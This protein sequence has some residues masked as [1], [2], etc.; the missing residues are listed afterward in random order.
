MIPTC[1][2]RQ[3]P[4]CGR[5]A[6]G[7]CVQ[8]AQSA[9]TSS[10]RAA[11]PLSSRAKAELIAVEGELDERAHTLPV[12]T[13][14]PMRA[15]VTAFHVLIAGQLNSD[16]DD[17]A[18]ELR[19]VAAASRLSYLV[20]D[21]L[22]GMETTPFGAGAAD[23]LGAYVDVDPDGSQLAFLLTYGHFCE[24]MPEVHRDYYDVGGNRESGFTLSHV[25]ADFAAFEMRDIILTE[26]G[27]PF[28]VAFP[29]TSLITDFDRLAETAPI[30]PLEIAGPVYQQLYRFYLRV[31]VEPALVT[32]AG[33]V[34]AAGVDNA[35]FVRFRAAVYAI[36]DVCRGLS[37]AIKRRIDKEAQ[38]DALEVEFM[39]WVAVNWSREFVVAL[40]T[41]LSGLT[42]V[43]VDR[44]L[45][46]FTLGLRPDARRVDHAGDGYL[47][48]FTHL[49]DSLLFSGDLIRLFL[50]ARNVLFVVNRLDKRRFDDLVSQAMEPQLIEQ[51]TALFARVSRLEVVRNHDWGDGEFD[52]LVYSPA[53]NVALHVQAKAAI[54]P[55]G[56][57]MVAAIE[58][59]GREGLEQLA[60][61]RALAQGD[62]DT[63][64]TQALGHQVAAVSLID[65]LLART[66]FGTAA[67]WGRSGAVALVNLLLLAE[68]IRTADPARPL[69]DFAAHA[70][71]RLDEIVDI[72][73]PRWVEREIDL[74]TLAL[75]LPILD[76]DF[77]SLGAARARAWTAAGDLP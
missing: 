48:P 70:T 11:T 1:R 32:D 17:G 68:V 13:K 33:M 45:D 59:R 22:A 5:A 18:A 21:L 53:E 75:R 37:R 27:G 34:E 6:E 39:E 73:S 9:T 3:T 31:L 10:C 64:L 29:P 76:Y 36:A 35:E 4:G 57:R 16:E 40:L 19:G 66:S 51:A 54:P 65:V 71:A 62:Q 15:L 60:R 30:L 38:S 43:A 67:L 28:G 2:V 58:A 14:L 8:E 20:H 72:A 44:L 55:Q 23:A 41:D 50:L 61:F 47:P 69:T 77:A 12:V 42:P 25:N 46:L 26:F 74:G 63:I 24:V 52:V 49:E 7:L 56:A